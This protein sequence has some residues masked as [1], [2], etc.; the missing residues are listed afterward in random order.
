MNHKWLSIVLAR[1]EMETRR[2]S[3]CKKEG[4]NESLWLYRN[5]NDRNVRELNAVSWEISRWMFVT[6]AHKRWCPK[7]QS[8]P[9]D[10]TTI[11]ER[12]GDA[13]RVASASIC[14]CHPRSTRLKIGTA[15][16]VEHRSPAFGHDFY[17]SSRRPIL[18]FSQL[19]YTSIA[20]TSDMPSLTLLYFASDFISLK[21]WD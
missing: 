1:M 21:Q 5:S 20:F 14:S 2:V 9:L 17:I 18:P 12:E 6:G 3:G 8:R 13:T 19:R 16:E 10:A 15:T 4:E 11:N 7:I